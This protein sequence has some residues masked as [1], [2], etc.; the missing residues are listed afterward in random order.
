M[1]QVLMELP[2]S[3]A[4]YHTGCVLSTRRVL[5]ER[6]SPDGTMPLRCRFGQ[7]RTASHRQEA[8]RAAHFYSGQAVPDAN[9][10]E[11]TVNMI[12]H[13]LLR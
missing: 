6:M 10:A 3:A 2:L 1:E 8:L 11:H 4:K 13:G 12:L 5:L 9:L 7:P